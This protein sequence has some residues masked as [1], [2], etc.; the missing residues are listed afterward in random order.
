MPIRQWVKNIAEEVLGGAPFKIGDIV[1]HPSGRMV[2]I[3]DGQY[4]GTYTFL[5]IGVG[6]KFC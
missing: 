3:I 1:K 2:K 6:K 5:I 4:W